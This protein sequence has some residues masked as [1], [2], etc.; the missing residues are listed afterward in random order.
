VSFGLHYYGGPGPQESAFLVAAAA[1]IWAVGDSAPGMPVLAHWSGGQWTTV[2]VPAGGTATAITGV[3]ANGSGAW[4][5]VQSSG[6]GGAAHDTVPV[7]ER[8]DGQSWSRVARAGLQPQYP[9]WPA[10]IAAPGEDYGGSLLCRFP[11]TSAQRAPFYGY[12][13]TCPSGLSAI[14]MTTVPGTKYLWAAGTR[15]HGLYPVAAF[16]LFAAR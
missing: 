5:T 14:T 16:S 12:A 1:G 6:N 13:W 11:L 2:P 3:T 4:L 9:A 15:Q 8:W 10:Q 7:L